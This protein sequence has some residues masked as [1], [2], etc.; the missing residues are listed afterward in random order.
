MSAEE[1][2]S[3]LDKNEPKS[4]Y[5]LSEAEKKSGGKDQKESA[6]ILPPPTS[7]HHSNGA[8]TSWFS[9]LFGGGGNKRHLTSPAA[10]IRKVP[11]KIEPKVYFANERTFLAW[12]HMAVTLA[13]ISM[14][15][16]AFAE[17]NEWSQIY[18]ICLMPVAIGFCVY[19]LWMFIKR[20]GMIR[21]KDPGPYEDRAGPIALAFLLALA[22][23]INFVVKLYDYANA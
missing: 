23:I 13:S 10:K 6:D 12:I 18:G 14:A 21:R 5:F 22:I 17:A 1:K 7:E 4:F 8:S 11:V 15:I 16:V 19:A 2:T 20:A 9:S 3:L